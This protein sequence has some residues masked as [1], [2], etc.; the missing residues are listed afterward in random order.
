M[1]KSN[2]LYVPSNVKD[3]LQPQLQH[4]SPMHPKREQFEQ[5]FIKKGFQFVAKKYGAIGI[6]FTIN[7]INENLKFVYDK[8]KWHLKHILK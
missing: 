2:L 4:P 3:C 1:T 8:A 7:K 5:D 6:R